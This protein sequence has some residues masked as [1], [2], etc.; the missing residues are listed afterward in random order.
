MGIT[1][2]DANGDISLTSP[3]V[4]GGV[5]GYQVPY[6][7][8]GTYQVFLAATGTGGVIYRSS[9]TVPPNLTVVAG[10]FPNIDNPQPTTAI[11]MT[12]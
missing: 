2:R 10:Q 3:C 1:L 12:P 8:Y 7:Y 4:N 11:L 5:Q 6:V 9:S